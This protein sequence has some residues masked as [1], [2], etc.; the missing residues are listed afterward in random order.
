M[1]TTALAFQ[2]DLAAPRAPE[3]R[4]VEITD[5]EIRLT[6]EPSE[7]ITPYETPPAPPPPPPP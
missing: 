5:I 7:R 3:P 1:T 6:V 2:V 4:V